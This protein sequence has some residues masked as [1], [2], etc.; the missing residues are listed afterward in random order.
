[1]SRP[2]GVVRSTCQLMVSSSSERTASSRTSAV[3]SRTRTDTVEVEAASNAA[4]MLK[5]C[6]SVAT[7]A[8]STNQV[9]A[10][11]CWA[12]RIGSTSKRSVSVGAAES[13]RASGLA[14]DTGR[15]RL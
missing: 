7:G 1:M 12:A 3:S 4:G 6:T 14:D 10:S 13:C 11:G 8:P 9:T 2:E 15:T 5:R